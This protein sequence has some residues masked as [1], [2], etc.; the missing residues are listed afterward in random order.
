MKSESPSAV[1]EKPPANLDKFLWPV[2]RLE[3][4]GRIDAALDILY[5][6][7]DDLLKARD[8]STVDELLR[9]A[10]VSSFSVDVLLGLLTATLPGRSKLPARSKFFRD[11]EVCIKER[12]EWEFGLLAGL[13][14]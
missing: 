6:R 14:S 2:T 1:L 7:V 10:D 4:L 11:V 5:D 9:Q 8:F 13:E 3:R 12:G